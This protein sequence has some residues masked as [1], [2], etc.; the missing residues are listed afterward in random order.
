MHFSQYIGFCFGAMAFASQACDLYDYSYEEKNKPSNSLMFHSA[1]GLCFSMLDGI[2]YTVKALDDLEFYL[3]DDSR[4]YASYW[5]DWVLKSASNPIL[6]R[7]LS[8]NYFGIG[9]WMPSELEEKMATMSMDEWLRNHGLQFSVGF[10]DKKA[11][12]PRMRLD[13]RWHDD[14]EGDVMMTIEVPL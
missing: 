11:G 3:D 14:Y 12:E 7:H 10:G 9:V 5:D 4:D 1:Q 6:S 13:Y 8:S 2:E